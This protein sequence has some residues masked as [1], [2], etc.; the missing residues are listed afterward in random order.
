[1]VH[2]ATYTHLYWDFPYGDGYYSYVQAATLGGYATFNVD[3]IGAG[4]SSHPASAQLTTTATAVALHDAI[5]ALRNGT[6]DGNRFEKVIWV[7]HSLGS[8][9]G[10]FEI[11]RYEDVDAAIFTGALHAMNM[12]GAQQLLANALPAPYDPMFAGAGLDEGYLAI[13]GEARTAAFYYPATTNPSVTAID[14]ANRDLVSAASL[15]ELFGALGQPPA[16]S[17]MRD[18]TI[19]VLLVVGAKDALFCGWLTAPYDCASSDS[20]KAYEAPYF[21]HARTLTVVTIPETGHDNALSTTAPLSSAA[22]LVWSRL[23]VAP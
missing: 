5:T 21:P 14:E 22:M 15:G 8:I 7:G 19:P 10:W 3:R 20:V 9:T 18:S 13:P 23:A 4:A 12:D 16:E 6:V 2:G 1:L 11:G 17:L